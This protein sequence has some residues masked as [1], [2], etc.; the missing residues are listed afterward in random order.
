MLVIDC[1]GRGAAGACG[2][3][4][5]VT[6]A[7]GFPAGCVSPD[8]LTPDRLRTTAVSPASARTPTQALIR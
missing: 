2:R 4:D 3:A 1:A 5:V 6:G 8:R 7:G